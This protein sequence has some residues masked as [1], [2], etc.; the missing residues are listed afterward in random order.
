MESSGQRA[1]Q[2][3]L[4]LFIVGLKTLVAAANS[5]ISLLSAAQATVARLEVD[6]PTKERLCPSCQQYYGGGGQPQPYVQQAMGPPR[7]SLPC[8]CGQPHYHTHAPG[9]EMPPPHLRG[10]GPMPPPSEENSPWGSPNQ[11]HGLSHSPS[12]SR[13]HLH[14]H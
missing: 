5:A 6:E 8:P 3:V 12:C 9:P 1:I 14:N 11:H 4:A 10:R 2:L 13:R 7:H